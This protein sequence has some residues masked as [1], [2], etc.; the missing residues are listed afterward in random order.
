MK[1]LDRYIA[2]AVI[3]GIA[4]VMF[5]LLAIDAF[6]ALAGEID[7]LKSGVYSLVD[8]VVYVALT[9]P[10][11]LYEFYP[12]AVFA[13]TLFGLG[14]MA[15]GSELTVMRTAGVSRLRIGFSAIWGAGVIVIMM[16][17]AGEWLM[18]LGEQQA[19]GMKLALQS[20]QQALST[21]QVLWVRDSG[22]IIKAS[23]PI[24]SGDASQT[25][26]ELR[27]VDVFLFDEQD[28]LKEQIS[29][30]R[31]IYLDKVWQ[32]EK[33]SQTQFTD[34]GVRL[35]HLDEMLMARLISQ[36]MLDVSVI[37]PR[38]MSVFQL[39]QTISFLQENGMNAQTYRLAW[40]VHSVTPITALVMSFAAIPFLFGSLRSGNAGQRLLTGIALGL[41]FYIVNRTVANIGDVYGL[42]PILAAS[43][44]TL[45]VAVG[46]YQVL[47]RQAN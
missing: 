27:N 46:S 38:H 45:I 24:L 43:I 19:R 5:A 37:Q 16:T 33:V 21:G 11:R 26:I 41:L 31:A 14:A 36:E 10:R 12:V 42:S 35:I 20:Q 34:D 7:E 9:L 44:P 3:Q 18:P 29:A 25:T 32:M 28:K 30:D 40:W 1:L 47:K 8:A 17:L 2:I 22:R 6:L 23:R 13:G 15:A 4:L 39:G